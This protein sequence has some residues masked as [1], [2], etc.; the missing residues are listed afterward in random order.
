MTNSLVGDTSHLNKNLTLLTSSNGTVVAVI[1]PMDGI[2]TNSAHEEYGSA[3]QTLLRLADA[4]FDDGIG[5]LADDN[6]PGVREV[7]NAVVASSESVPNAA[8]ASMFLAAWGQFIDHDINHTP[9]G[10]TEFAGIVVPN[11]DPVF[12]PGTI[13]P[14]TRV[15]PETGTGVSTPREY[16]NEITAFMDAS[17]VYGSDQETAD[18]LRTSGGKLMLDENGFLVADTHGDLMTGDSR[19]AENAMLTAMHSLF[20]REHNRWVDIL[21]ERYPELSDDDL[22]AAARTRVEAEIQAI[23]FNEYLPVLLGDGAIAAYS[24][25][26]SSVNPGVSV[27]FS[28]AVYRFGHSLLNSEIQLLDEDGN[29]AAGGNL[30]LV[31]AFFAPDMME[32]GGLEAI[33]RGLGDS[34]AQEVDTLVV[35]D[36]RSA[37]FGTGLDLAAFNL[38]RGRDLGVASYNDLREAVGLQR[39]TSFSDVT[40]DARIAAQLQILYGD[41]DQLDAWVGGLAEDHVNGGMLGELFSTIIID[42]FTRIRDGDPYWSQAGHLPAGELDALWSTTLADIIEWNTDIDDIQDHLFIAYNRIGGNKKDNELEGGDSHD[43]ILGFKGDDLLVG[44]ADDDQLIGGDGKDSMFGGSGNDILEGNEGKDK[45]RGGSG[46]DTIRGD[47]GK[48]DLKGQAGNDSIDGGKGKDLAKG[49]SGHDTINGGAGKDTAKGGSGNDIVNGG[50]ANDKLLGQTGNDSING[51]AG[52]DVAKGGKGSD[53]LDGGTGRDIL[54]GNGGQDQFQFTTTLN[55][56][57]NVDTITDF[58]IGQDS[59]GLADTIFSAL[60]PTIEA[61]E[62]RIGKNARDADDF[63]IYH[64]GSGKLYYDPDADGGLNKILFAKLD[65]NLPLDASD[66]VIISG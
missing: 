58:K 55:R 49:G 15:D 43:L 46:D 51:G 9:A 35:E 65:K 61:S 19:A 13:M 66:F 32:S 17:M 34:T 39:A 4:N 28:T 10:T 48:D 41:V 11:N 20:A 33:L 30:T 25:Y 2:G 42:Q 31:E 27:E 56:K 5:D 50:S 12:A 6:R 29:T 44:N 47:G 37:L 59:I 14:F 8:G 22:Y 24:G 63:L 7:S 57:S 40:S 45:G 23:T 38:Q 62:L 52:K 64:S 18:A 36:L 3:G 1:R 54:S 16:A 26:D 53:I 60:G 21:A